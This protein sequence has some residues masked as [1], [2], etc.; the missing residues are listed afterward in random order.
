MHP[1]PRK[2]PKRA[3]YPNYSWFADLTGK[4]QI[5]AWSGA[6]YGGVILDDQSNL[7]Q[8]ARRDGQVQV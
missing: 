6:Q 3:P 4:M 8:L 7:K 1:L 2:V 5:R